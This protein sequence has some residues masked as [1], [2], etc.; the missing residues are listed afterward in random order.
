M[1]PNCRLE[2]GSGA[3]VAWSVEFGE[4]LVMPTASSGMASE[5]SVLIASLMGVVA[6]AR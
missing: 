6:L 1:G 5:D 2:L 3:A 4:V